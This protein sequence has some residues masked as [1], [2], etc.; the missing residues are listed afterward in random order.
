MPEKAAAVL[1]RR[2][3]HRAPESGLRECPEPSQAGRTI[4]EEH[5]HQPEP[6]GTQRCEPLHRV[7]ERPFEQADLENVHAGRGEH[8]YPVPCRARLERHVTD[9]CAQRNAAAEA[10]RGAAQCVRLPGTEGAVP[11]ILEIED[12][13][14]AGKSQLRFLEI[15]NAREK[16]G[17]CASSRLCGKDDRKGGRAQAAGEKRRILVPGRWTATFSGTGGTFGFRCRIF[18]ARVPPLREHVLFLTGRLAEPRLRRVLEGLSD[19]PFDW[20]IRQMGVKVAALLSPEIVRRRLGSV[21]GASRALLPGRFRGDP[22]ELERAFGI[23]FLRGPDDLADL[24]EWLGRPGGPP[25]LSRHDMRIF[26]EIVDA[27]LLDVAGL[28]ARAEE[29]RARGADVIDLGCLPDTPFP[30]LEETV[31]ELRNAGFAV[32]VDSGD[33]EELR[34]AGAA[35]ADFLLSLTEDSLEIALACESVPVLVPAQSGDLE[36]LARAC[37]RM[38]RQ[39]RRFLA[40]PILDPIHMGFTRSVVRYAQFRERFPEV[41][42]LMG[43]GNLTELTDADTTG[44]TMTVLG[45]ASELR[46]ENLLAVSVSPHCRRA[47]EEA[48]LAR[49]MLYRARE[50]GSLPQGIHPGLLCLRDRRPFPLSSEEIAEEAAQVRDVNFRI[51]VAE[52]GIHVYNRHGHHVGTD[53]D[54]LFPL[55]GVAE[56]GPHAFYLG[57]ELARAEIAWRLGKRYVQD[58]PLAWGCAVDPVTKRTSSFDPAGA[59]L[60]ASRQRRRR[61]KG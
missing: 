49:R 24:P 15:R 31:R 29:L 32:S 14:A 4:G 28:M 50:D 54:S 52:D 45:I 35:G 8:R 25:D 7:P 30:H 56:D 43:I 61:E 22:G 23:P 48:D 41:E 2:I 33:T 21:E 57:A 19:L 26:A 55:L 44:I 36:S 18:L 6:P 39:G 12:I 1:D 10:L 51:Q 42:M 40:D 34:R 9:G 5:G 60:R 38:L 53:P 47:I 59:T 20:E 27:P 58:E 11:R 46:I 17:Q 16:S 3:Q 13:D 37:E